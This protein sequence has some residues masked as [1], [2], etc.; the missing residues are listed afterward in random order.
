MSYWVWVSMDYATFGIHVSDGIVDE[1][2]PI[3]KWT[4]GKPIGQV[5]HYYQGRDAVII[6]GI[7]SV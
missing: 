4:I 6:G 1:A 3:A 5:A 7:P 2:A